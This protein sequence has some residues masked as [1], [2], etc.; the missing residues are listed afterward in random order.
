MKRG[1]LVLSFF[2]PAG[3]LTA[4]SGSSDGGGA[5]TQS[6]TAPL[7]DT[8]IVLCGDYAYP[9]ATHDNDVSCA[10]VGAT[11]TVAGVEISNGLDPVPAGQDAVYGRDTY[12]VFDFTKLDA[13]GEALADQNEDWNDGGNEL[14]GT[15][16][17]CVRDNVTGLV[18][19]VKTINGLRDRDYTYT[20]HDSN[21]A[22]NGGNAGFADTGMGG[23]NNCW[24]T[25]R[26]DTKKYVED[27]NGAYLCGSN[28]WRLPSRDEL[29]TLRHLGIDAPAIEQDYF[30]HTPA[31][32]FWTATPRADG[33]TYAWAVDFN[34]GGEIQLLKAQAYA[35]R[36]VRDAN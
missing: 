25:Q 27:V 22:T 15:K 17:S 30:P 36:L 19:E 35:V 10:A 29:K 28:A 13:N 1:L 24:N 23:S 32:N 12:R 7:N 18:W 26:C 8:G 33:A 31:A 34:N 21:T 11:Q 14:S 2:L 3:L 5:W 16:W 20:W 9:E 4:C 6:A